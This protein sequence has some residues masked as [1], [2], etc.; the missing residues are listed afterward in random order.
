V[1]ASRR[2]AVHRTWPATVRARPFVARPP[3][4]NSPAIRRRAAGGSVPALQLLNSQGWLKYIGDKQVHTEEQARNYLQQGP[5]KSY[6]E[7]GFGLSLVETKADQKPI[8]MCGL[9]KRTALP[10]PDIG[11]AFLHEYNNQGYAYEIANATL[12]YAKSELD[13]SIVLAIVMPENTKSIALLEK[14]GLRYV[15]L[16]QL[17]TETEKLLL[18][19]T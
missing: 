6:S 15:E 8:G 18:Y 4:L 2:G 13:I 12:Q 14:I 7:N 1:A 11:F 9:L 5:I 10:N 17:P 19:S 16:F 3:P